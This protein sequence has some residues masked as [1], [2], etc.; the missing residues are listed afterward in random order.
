MIARP[1]GGVLPDKQQQKMHVLTQKAKLVFRPMSE[2]DIGSLAHWF[3]DFEDVGLFERKMPVPVSRE[4]VIE[5][6]KV[7]LK[8]HDPPKSIWF[9]LE[10]A[11][12]AA[13]GICGIQAI[14]YIH[15]DAVIPLFVA[16]EH[17]CKGLGTAMVVALIELAFD[18]LRLNR[19]STVYRS[20]NTATEKLVSSLGFSQEGRIREGWYADGEHY[21][22]IHV[23]LLKAEWSATKD[24]V[25]ER[26][27]RSSFELT[28]RPELAD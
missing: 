17:R 7:T 9:I 20:N 21:D 24:L 2:A 18:R 15:G 8:P 11:D 26:L 1:N 6:W 23:G 16:R 3:A 22:T 13:V 4:A 25:R 27:S 28:N 14:N 19:I 5:N 10:D 12:A